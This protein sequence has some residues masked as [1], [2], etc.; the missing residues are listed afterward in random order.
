MNNKNGFFS[1]ELVISVMVIVC[2]SAMTFVNIRQAR[3][4][5]DIE[6][7]TR[8]LVMD[9]QW[10]QQES[11]GNSL[12]EMDD[13]CLAVREEEYVILHN[14]FEVKKR[15]P[16]SR[17][18]QVLGGGQRELR[19]DEWGRPKG[20]TMQVVVKSLS[21][22]EQRRIVIAASTGRIRIE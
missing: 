18:F 10:V 3:S 2:F 21:G 15:R 8:E 20:N 9:I 1:V 13:W 16:F 14:H 4:S 17:N 22:Q 5:Y 11:M 7:L 19:F 6:L 12:H